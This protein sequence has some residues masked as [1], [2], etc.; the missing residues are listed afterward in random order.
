MTDAVTICNIALSHLGATPIID[1]DQDTPEAILCRINYLP[2]LLALLEEKV[3]SFAWEDVIFST[4]ERPE[5]GGGWRYP[6]DPSIAIIHRVYTNPV[7]R[8]RLP[9]WHVEGRELVAPYY[10]QLW[11]TAL[12]PNAANAALTSATFRYALSLRLAADWCAGMTGNMSLVRALWGRYDEAIDL[13]GMSDGMQ[14][15]R[16]PLAAGRL[17][18]VRWS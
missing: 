16:E 12:V 5:W 2:T 3:F 8:R 4:D 9:Q 11:A 14:G 6:I 1:I 10:E 17:H 13:A 7:T 18:D 15:S